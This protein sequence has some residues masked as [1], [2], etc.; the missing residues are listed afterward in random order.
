MEK[1]QHLRHGE[2]AGG[3]RE[4]QGRAPKLI[5]LIDRFGIRPDLLHGGIA[6]TTRHGA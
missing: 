4:H 2:L 1:E 6:V 3:S 5:G